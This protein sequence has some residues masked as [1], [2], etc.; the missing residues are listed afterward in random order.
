MLKPALA[1]M[2]LLLT[3]TVIPTPAA[4]AEAEAGFALDYHLSF[5]EDD[6]PTVEVRVSG[7][8]TGSTTLT[9]TTGSWLGA[10]SEPFSSVFVVSRAVTPE[11]KSLAWS[12]RGNSI[13]VANGSAPEFVL[14]YQPDMSRLGRPQGD[15]WQAF[16]VFR[17]KAVFFVAETVFPMPETEPARVTVRFTLPGR[18]KVFSN[19]EEENGVLVARTDL[20]GNLR[21]D[22][23]KA[24]FT[25]GEPFFSVSHETAWGDKYVYVWFDRDIAD[26]MW[27]PSWGTTQWEEAERYMELAEQFAGYFREK[28]GP[29]P[30]RTVVFTN[31]KNVTGLNVGFNVDFYHWMQIWP[32]DSVGDLAHHVLHAYDFW[33]S[34]SKMWFTPN[35]SQPSGYLREGLN[36]YYEQVVPAEV[37]GDD[38]YLGKLYVF[39]ALDQRGSRFG[40]QA[41]EMHR[42]YNVS[43]LKV[44]LLDQYIRQVTGGANNLDDFIRTLWDSVKDN[45]QPHTPSAQEIDAAFA[46]VVGQVNAGYINDLVGQAT[47]DR[48]AFA[49]LEPSFQAYVDW[50]SDEY[51][52]GNPAVLCAF[53]DIAAAKGREW[54]HY[55]NSPHTLAVYRQTALQPFKEYL[56]GLGKA[57]FT[58]QDI[59]AALN[60][61]TGKDHAGFFEFWSGTGMSIA[62]ADFAPLAAWDPNARSEGDLVRTMSQIGTLWTEHYLPGIRQRG[63]I[64]L[65]EPAQQ[66]T[67]GLQVSLRSF[68][69][70]P[71]E[72]E[73]RAAISGKG[74]S[75]RSSY[76]VLD[77]GV[78]YTQASFLVR[79]SDPEQRTLSFDLILPSFDSHPSFGVFKLEGTGTTWMGEVYSL[80]P[81]PP[82]RFPLSVRGGEIIL[83]DTLLSGE[84]FTV[85]LEDQVSRA[86]PAETVVVRGQA[87]Q[88]VDV[89]LFDQY[90]FLRGVEYTK[91]TG[92]TAPTVG[93]AALIV[94]LAGAGV[95]IAR[96]LKKVRARGKATGS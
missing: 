65:D 6:H 48:E 74:V 75:F 35:F 3:L 8:P 38:K 63:E 51:F 88:P 71:P 26:M 60:H 30:P 89:E 66:P 42:T 82:V 61:V 41:N 94:L 9:F 83:P 54:P 18:T 20:F 25:G 56:A 46:E 29:L 76:Q 10:L 50:I 69:A 15:M 77:R 64:V 37:L 84:S 70:F 45:T 39:L 90:G 85:H 52:W 32:R 21:Y 93:L 43:G 67:I 4:G 57:K 31:V 17:R 22:F 81:A 58:E 95:L 28:I 53:W 40:I 1:F 80:H 27:L 13:D 96:R 59:V 47:F 79:I 44:Y 12:W 19:L 36:T 16:A 62:P 78:Y 55:V 87:G 23:A 24:Y 92:T 49:S 72:A 14:A 2:V 91:A 34:Q 68:T 86:G 5:T 33:P 11:G 7:A 73:A